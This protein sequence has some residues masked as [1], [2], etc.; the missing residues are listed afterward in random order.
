MGLVEVT[1]RLYRG[2]GTCRTLDGERTRVEQ[3][4]N[5]QRPPK[6]KAVSGRVRSPIGP[7][8]WQPGWHKK[9][10]ADGTSAKVYDADGL[11]VEVEQYEPTGE[12]CGK[13]PLVNVR[14]ETPDGEL[15]ARHAARRI[16]DDAYDIHVTDAAGNLRVVLH[17]SDIGRGEPF[18]IQE[19]WMDR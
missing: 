7:D 9:R 14:I 4:P 19:E 17:H 2:P 11:L 10:S 1:T 12:Y 5:E 6:P 15:I 16:S 13:E 18:T 8:R 3:D